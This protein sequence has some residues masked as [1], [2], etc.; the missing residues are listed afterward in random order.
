MYYKNLDVWKESI[1]LSVEIYNI[2]DKFPDTEKYG[3]VSQMRRS[4]VSIPSNIAEGSARWSDKDTI[5][6]I[7]IAIG[8]LAEL[9][10]QIIIANRINLLPNI[11]EL[12]QKIERLAALLRGLKKYLLKE[13]DKKSY[14]EAV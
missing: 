4:A 7:D 8:S 12:T 9:D 1:N 11:E 5:K 6:F 2:T 3:L 10:T 13:K 14:G